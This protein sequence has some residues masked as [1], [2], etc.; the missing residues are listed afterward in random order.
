MCLGNYTWVKVIRKRSSLLPS[1]VHLGNNIWVEVTKK[2][3]SLLS[4]SGY[5]GNNTRME[6]TRNI[7]CSHL[8]C[9]LEITPECRSPN[10]NYSS[11]YLVCLRNYTR[12]E[13]TRNVIQIVLYASLAQYSCECY[14]KKLFSL[15]SS[16][17]F[18]NYTKVKLS[19]KRHFLVISHANLGSNTR[20]PVIRKS[21]SL[22]LSSLILGNNPWM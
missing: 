11:Y 1:S 10:I 15:P 4:T 6:I 7:I 18:G 5:L 14:K 12:V 21:C 13:V 19:R 3:S 9:M 17:H 2:S 8:G 20:E 16:V 22:L